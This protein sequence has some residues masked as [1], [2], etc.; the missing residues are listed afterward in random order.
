MMAQQAELAAA[1]G[2]TVEET[3]TSQSDWSEDHD[4]VDVNDVT[5]DAQKC[6]AVD[7][8]CR[9]SYN[10]DALSA[11]N[12]GGVFHDVEGAMSDIVSLCDGDDRG[13]D[14]DMDDTSMSSRGSP[15]LLNPNNVGEM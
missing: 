8:N 4:E 13:H 3:E 12:V 9:D 10:L 15:R 7:R 6:D 2:E 5:R 11:A 14:G 1:C